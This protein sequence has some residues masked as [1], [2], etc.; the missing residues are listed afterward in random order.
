MLLAIAAI[1][2]QR[3]PT[4]AAVPLPVRD[5]IRGRADFWLLYVSSLFI[6]IALFTPFVFMADYVDTTG[7]DGSAA[8]LL[9]IIGMASIVGR[10]GFGAIAARI[11]I[12]GLYRLSFLVLAGSFVVWLVADTRY[13]ML[14]TFAVVLGVAYGGFIALSPAVVAVRFGTLGMGGVLGAL[15]TAAGVGGLVGPPLMG[16]IIDASGHAAAQW[17]ALGSGLIGTALLFRME[18]MGES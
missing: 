6:S 10:L 15:Y 18:P 12:L 7:T 5:A 16:R 11:G 1:G 8:V 2:A 13:W 4:A 9:G 3:P 17:T 14:I